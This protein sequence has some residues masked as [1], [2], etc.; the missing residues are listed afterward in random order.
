MREC[1]AGKSCARYS[2]SARASE[3]CRC[4]GTFSAAPVCATV[5]EPVQ[6][7]RRWKAGST[8]V[9]YKAG[10]TAVKYCGDGAERPGVQ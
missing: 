5:P 8:A 9:K 4:R 6:S 7:E 1:V 2:A 10:S 3:K